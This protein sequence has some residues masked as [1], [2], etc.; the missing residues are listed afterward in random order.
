[1]MLHAGLI[2][3]QTVLLQS[4]GGVSI[5]GLQ[6]AHVMGIVPIITSSSDEKLGHAKVRGAACGINYKT[7]PEWG[8]RKPSI[9][10]AAAASITCSKSAAH[11]RSPVRSGVIGVGGKIS[12]IG[13]LSG[14]T[15]ELNPGLIFAKRANVQGISVGPDGSIRANECRDF[16]DETQAGDRSRVRLRRGESRLPSHGRRRAFRQNRHPGR[17][18]TATRNACEKDYCAATRVGGNATSMSVPAFGAL[19]MLK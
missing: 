18:K 8:T 17:R 19:L 16:G 15:T 13:G 2:A 11:T 14:G 10:T 7:T 6:F 4:T 12:I 5:F 9:S 3:G 1:M